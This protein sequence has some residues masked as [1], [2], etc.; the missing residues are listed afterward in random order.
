MDFEKLVTAFGWPGALL[1][2]LGFTA[3][4]VSAFLKVKLFDDSPDTK[5]RPKGYIPLV[6][7][8]HRD[9]LDAVKLSLEKTDE[10]NAEIL[11]LQHEHLLLSR[12][13]RADIKELIEWH[14]DHPHPQVEIN[15]PKSPIIGIMAPEQK[16]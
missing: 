10:R 5:G 16:Q 6:V 12:D 11:K 3:W 4:R 13:H 1:I 14:R 2:A 15:S 9:M 7:E 8:G